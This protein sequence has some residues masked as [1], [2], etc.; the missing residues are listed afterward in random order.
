MDNL[1]KQ[2]KELEDSLIEM[3]KWVGE[4]IG[5]ANRTNIRLEIILIVISA[6]TSGTLWML[7]AGKLPEITTWVGAIL[8][9]IV[10]I[11][12]I[13]QK[14]LGPKKVYDD[15][16]PLYK[17]IGEFI[18]ELRSQTVF[19]HQDIKLAWHKYKS[20]QAGL[21]AFEHRAKGNKGLPPIPE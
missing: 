3:Y 15:A 18:A 14:S 10:T 16:L 7:L 12:T 21:W 4:I 2:K 20:L 17:N 9:T 11:I 1:E 5:Q 8:S 19:T 13:Y 6:I